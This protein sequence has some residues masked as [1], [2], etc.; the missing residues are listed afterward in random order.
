LI[1][2]YSDEKIIFYV[3]FYEDNNPGNIKIW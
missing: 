1:L 3:H 2:V